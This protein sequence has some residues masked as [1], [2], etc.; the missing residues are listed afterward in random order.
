MLLHQYNVGPVAPELVGCFLGQFINHAYFLICQYR[1]HCDDLI[2]VVIWQ[3]AVHDGQA[4]QVPVHVIA[5]AG[6]VEIWTVADAVVVV[7]VIQPTVIIDGVGPQMIEAV[8]MPVMNQCIGVKHQRPHGIDGSSCAIEGVPLVVKLEDGFHGLVQWKW[9]HGKDFGSG[10]TV[11]N[12]SVGLLATVVLYDVFEA[13]MM[14]RSKVL[15]C[16]YVCIVS[17]AVLLYLFFRLWI[18]I[19]VI[20]PLNQLV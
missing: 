9:F 16:F 2:I 17:L 19:R 8:H 11:L 20:E 12:V 7:T 6:N 10:F 5:T 3:V 14:L 15:E 18:Y 1:P 4:E 13:V